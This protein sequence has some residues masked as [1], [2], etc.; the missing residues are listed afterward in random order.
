MMSYYYVTGVSY[1]STSTATSVQQVQPTASASAA[2]EY[3]VD[4]VTVTGAT[5]PLSYWPL[6]RREGRSV[7]ETAKRE[8]ARASARVAAELSPTV[9]ATRIASERVRGARLARS[10]LPSR[11]GFYQG[12]F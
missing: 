11:F 1:Q 9:R 10:A 5:A 7:M 8:R 6:S 4:V 12:T 3:T 2:Q